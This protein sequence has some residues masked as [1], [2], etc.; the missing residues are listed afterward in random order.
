MSKRVLGGKGRRRGRKKG[1]RTEKDGGNLRQIYGTRESVKGFYFIINIQV[2]KLAHAFYPRSKLPRFFMHRF[3]C[4]PAH[5][6]RH[7]PPFHPSPWK[8]ARKAPRA[9]GASSRNGQ[10]PNSFSR[11]VTL[12]IALPFPSLSPSSSSSSSLSPRSRYR[13]RNSRAR[14]APDTGS[15][16]P[17]SKCTRPLPPSPPRTNQ[18]K[19]SSHRVWCR[20]RSTKYRISKW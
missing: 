20:C 4:P 18:S 5:N 6:P 12:A 7:F 3:L 13:R 2:F 9:P 1:D 17:H 11:N 19:P 15:R 10:C 8:N 16:L 14:W